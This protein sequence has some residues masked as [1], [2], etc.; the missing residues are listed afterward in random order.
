MAVVMGALHDVRALI[1]IHDFYTGDFCIK[2]LWVQ[3]GRGNQGWTD[4]RKEKRR[5]T[6][7][8]CVLSRL[9][10]APAFYA[11][12]TWCDHGCLSSSSS[13]SLPIL[14]FFFFLSFFLFSPAAL[15]ASVCVRYAN[16]L[17][18]RS[19]G[20][21][22]SVLPL[23]AAAAPEVHNETPA[24]GA[25]DERRRGRM[26]VQGC[27]E[28]EEEEKLV[29]DEVHKYWHKGETLGDGTWRLSASC[30]ANE[31]VEWTSCQ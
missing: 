18:F 28:E 12:G 30:S 23:R 24:G 19:A 13:P 15:S 1:L 21:T 2:P 7:C 14:F 10:Y 29:W 11:G 27:E 8:V 6:M 26:S 16:P 31:R 22:D 9:P 5:K 4:K 17:A 25:R 3:R 20:A